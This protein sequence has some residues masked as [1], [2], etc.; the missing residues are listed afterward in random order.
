MFRLQ[1]DLIRREIQ[2]QVEWR[3]VEVN[4]NPLLRDNRLKPATLSYILKKIM[5]VWHRFSP[6]KPSVVCFKVKKKNSDFM[7]MSVCNILES[8][9]YQYYL[10][11]DDK[12][13]IFGP[14]PSCIA[15]PSTFK[16]ML[17]ESNSIKG[18]IEKFKTILIK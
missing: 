15:N 11:E 7:L 5:S 9:S 10:C 3:K 16:P 14:M 13:L 12:N 18:A 8:E 4:T 17:G 1:I 6:N 2:F